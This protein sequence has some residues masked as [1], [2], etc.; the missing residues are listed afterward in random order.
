[1]VLEFSSQHQ[2]KGDTMKKWK[3]GAVIGAI[4][5]AFYVVSCPFF[6]ILFTVAGKQSSFDTSLAPILCEALSAPSVFWFIAETLS[7]IFGVSPIAVHNFFSSSNAGMKLLVML[8]LVMW[9]GIGALTGAGTG[10]LIGKYRGQ[11]ISIITIKNDIKIG[12]FAGFIGFFLA[13]LFWYFI[14][15]R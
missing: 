12:A 7:G 5:G 3:F 9:S 15:C 11:E 8:I 1:M 13:L 10:Y 4:I 2:Q 14:F 6:Y